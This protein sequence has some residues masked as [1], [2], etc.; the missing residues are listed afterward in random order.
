MMMVWFMRM[1]I[2]MME[3]VG[4]TRVVVEDDK[5]TGVQPV[6]VGHRIA[7]EKRWKGCEIGYRRCN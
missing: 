2:V 4:I 5:G 1:L 3:M 7:N 6:A